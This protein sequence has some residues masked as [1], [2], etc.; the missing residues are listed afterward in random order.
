MKRFFKYL[1]NLWYFGVAILIIILTAIFLRWSD[2]REELS[3]KDWVIRLLPEVPTSTLTPAG[4][5]SIY[6]SPV[7]FSTITPTPVPTYREEEYQAYKK[8]FCTKYQVPA[9]LYAKEMAESS[10]KYQLPE[11]LL[12]AIAMLESGGGRAMAYNNMFGFGYIHFDTI[13]SGIERVAKALAGQGT[14]GVYYVGKTLEGKL[15][16]YNQNKGYG[17]RIRAIMN[18]IKGL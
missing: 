6:V 3:Y 14:D 9:C 5:I 1:R 18:E 7:I 16:A 15:Y 10:F 4:S 13:P 8:Y 11:F 17:E 2:G 12:G